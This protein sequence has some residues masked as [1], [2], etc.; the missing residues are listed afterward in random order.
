VFI[1]GLHCDGMATVPLGYASGA[2]PLRY[3]DVYTRMFVS[4]MVDGYIV[5]L[6]IEF[7]SS[8]LKERPWVDWDSFLFTL[9][10][11]DELQPVPITGVKIPKP[12]GTR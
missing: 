6:Q 1:K 5:L 3:S 4:C 2:V 9:S 11:T 12:G 7:R 10:G 8:V